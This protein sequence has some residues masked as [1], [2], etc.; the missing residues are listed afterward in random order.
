LD[1]LT[2]AAWINLATAEKALELY[3][4][5]LVHYR[6][7]FEL[8]P[9]MLTENS[10]INHE[11]GGVYVLAGMPDSAAAVFR[12][13]AGSSDRG[14][15]ARGLRSLAFLAMY[16]GRYGE[17]AGLLTEAADLNRTTGAL[18]SELRSRLL[19]ATT[20][21]QR[22]MVREAAAQLDSCF[23]RAAD[24]RLAPT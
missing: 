24:A 4:S 21:A 2:D 22:G 20:F 15:R 5:A 17:A 23:V 7:A 13:L 8:E 11:F 18:L 19:L 16:R 12:T 9:A 1:S 10:N 3:D 6:R 14:A